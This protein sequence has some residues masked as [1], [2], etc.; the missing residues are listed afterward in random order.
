[1]HRTTHH[2]GGRRGWR[3]HSRHSIFFRLLMIF[4]LSTLALMILISA[5]AHFLATPE[6]LVNR[7]LLNNVG[8]YLEYLT[9]EWGEP[10]DKDRAEQLSQR[11]GF[12][13]RIS[14]QNQ[15]WFESEGF[16]E[17]LGNE[18]LR[19]IPEHPQI[20]VGRYRHFALAR[21]QHG[22]FQYLFAI[23]HAPLAKNIGW[24]ITALLA[25][26]AL[27]LAFAHHL[28]KRLLRPV[29][30]LTEG[31]QRI[32]Q[33]ELDYTVPLPKRK[34]ELG[35][36]IHAFNDMSQQINRTIKSKEQLLLDVSHELRSPITRMK[37]L[38]EFIDNLDMRDK[39]GD[40]IR[41]MEAMVTE[42]LETA[43]MDNPS[44]ALR[45]QPVDVSALLRETIEWYGDTP[46]GII[47]NSH[48]P[49]MVIEADH[50]RLRT[51]FRNVLDNAL[52]YSRNQQKPVEVNLQQ[53]GR[54]LLIEVRDHGVGIPAE[55]LELVFQPFY[56]VDKSRS[57]QTGGYGL[58]LSLCKKIL[59]AHHGDIWAQS[60]YNGTRFFINLPGTK[61][62]AP[63]A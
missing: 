27:V 62:D 55:Q 49:P 40:D 5:T 13:L 10:P 57:N 8:Q 17:F 63:Y 30:D 23:K 58:G 31:I 6:G 22:D 19:S 47:T 37:V 12:K 41:S 54:E 56:R 9:R 46:P 21:F 51:V 39:L 45:L 60:D 14:G 59:R 53:K 28:V 61:T 4:G 29:R 3:R 50:D 44:D 52:K 42:L 7:F 18:H 48:W 33:G 34:D 2:H 1:M 11:L 38:L 25:I 20:E 43:R 36:L 16:P 35:Q 32:G 26:I 15:V 24:F